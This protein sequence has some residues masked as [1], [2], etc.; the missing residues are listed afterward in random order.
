MSIKY[1]KKDWVVMTEETHTTYDNLVLPIWEKMT[2]TIMR[3]VPEA[4]RKKCLEDRAKFGRGI[5]ITYKELLN[6]LR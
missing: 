2:L 1:K 6:K 5:P 3:R 4:E